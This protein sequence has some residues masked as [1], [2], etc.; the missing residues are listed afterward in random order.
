LEPRIQGDEMTTFTEN[1]NYLEDLVYGVT[2]QR[3]VY[4]DRFIKDKSTEDDE[5]DRRPSDTRAAYW[6]GL[7]QKSKMFINAFNDPIINTDF[8][9]PVLAIPTHRD[10][11]GRNYQ[12]ALQGNPAFASQGTKTAGM[13]SLSKG[14]ETTSALAKI[15]LDPRKL[16]DLEGL[17]AIRRACKFGLEDAVSR[18]KSTCVHYILDEITMQDVTDKKTF[19]LYSGGTGVPIT[20]SEL[21]FLFRNWN[22]YRNSGKIIFYRAFNVCAAPWSTDAQEGWAGYALHLLEKNKAT[23]GE[24]QLNAGK[25]FQTTSNWKGIIGVLHNIALA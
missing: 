4:V 22:R 3:D 2:K 20:T 10:M 16:A 21:R 7:T 11:E 19:P 13:R 12:N 8:S 9:K 24:T 14:D 25:A 23:W 6:A 18:R 5:D 1:F 15:D 17:L